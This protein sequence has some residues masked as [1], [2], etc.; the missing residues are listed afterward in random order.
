VSPMPDA[1]LALCAYVVTIRI[2]QQRARQL[3]V[4]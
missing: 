1:L 3:E 2:L 4:R